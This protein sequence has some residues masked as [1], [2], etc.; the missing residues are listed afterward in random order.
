MARDDLND[1][2]GMECVPDEAVQRAIPYRTLALA[3]CGILAASLVSFTLLTGDGNGGEPVAIAAIVTP[4]KPDP[5][6]APLP[7]ALPQALTATDVTGSTTVAKGPASADDL[8]LQSGVRIVRRGGGAPSGAVVIQIPPVPGN[9]LNPSPDKRLAE[10]SRFG[11]LP[12]SG[13]DGS[14]ASDVYA[15]PL[16]TAGSLK[17]GAPQIA[18][19]VGGMG[20][21]AATTQ[22]AVDKLPGAVTLGFAPYGTDLE[23]QVAQARAQGHEVLLQTPMEPFDFPQNDPGPHTLRQNADAAETLDDLHWLM[24]RFTGYAGVANFLGARFTANKAA[25]APVLRDIAS[26]GLFYVDDGAS[27]QSVV[28][29]AALEAGLSAI[30]ADVVID[31]SSKPEAIAASLMA[32]EALARKNG[33]ALGIA[34]ALPVSVEQV[35][36]FARALEGRGI[37]LV[38]VSALVVN[39]T[40]KAAA[41]RQ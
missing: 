14:R 8:E 15:R 20:L 19:M 24:G 41:Q 31:A 4:K 7:A 37:A 3:G 34:S 2:L 23:K 36:R 35:S 30:K 16:L 21:S 10:K 40:P 9:Q 12:K 26:R 1:P 25:L 33:S 13:S 6:A 5:V 27:P 18:I 17:P 38:P 39:K 22:D 28:A 29:D 11:L 32:L